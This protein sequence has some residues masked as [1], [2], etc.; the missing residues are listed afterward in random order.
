M[1]EIGEL[2]GFRRWKFALS[3]AVVATCLVVLFLQ[4]KGL[5]DAKRYIHQC[6]AERSGSNG[7]DVT[8]EIAAQCFT[9]YEE[10][11]RIRS[12]P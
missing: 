10:G 9:D 3:V 2:A 8:E 5:V 4:I 6:R 12:I 1:T 7:D 11:R